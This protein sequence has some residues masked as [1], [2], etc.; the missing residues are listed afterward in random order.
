[1]NRKYVLAAGT[2][3]AL[4]MAFVAGASHSPGG[5]KPAPAEEKK[6]D[7]PNAAVL[8]LH[9]TAVF[10]MAGVMRD[11]HQ[12]KY[13]VWLLNKKKEEISKQLVGWR[14]EYIQI[15]KELQQNP[16]HPQK[17]E[18]NQ[19][20]LDLA[21]KVEDED[22]KINKQLNDDASAIISDLYD[23]MKAVV[24]RTA[25]Q[26]GFQIVLAYP[27]AVTP[28]EMKNPYIKELKLKPPAAQPFYVSP[29]V[30]ITAR[31]VKV[32]NE[33][34]PPL[35]PVT[36]QPVDVSKLDLPASAP[37]HLPGAVPMKP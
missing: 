8:V 24:D 11:F 10:N 26:N 19:G 25:E 9:K 13:Q 17:D 16:N 4:V 12:A 23:K 1:M 7:A 37:M 5:A 34:H 35:D 30:D 27:D 31:V 2:G 33:K 36:K 21:R 3:A 28:E 29:D 14:N 6:P 15:Q 18:L 22:R 20:L 32:L